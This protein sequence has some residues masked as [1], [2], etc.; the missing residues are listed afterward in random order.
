MALVKLAEAQVKLSIGK[1]VD[2]VQKLGD[3]E[4]KITNLIAAG[5]I[6]PSTDGL[7][8]PEGLVAG[9]QAAS[10]CIIPPPPPTDVVVQ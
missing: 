9:A 4:L 2:A 3:Y 5:K 10:A 8:T 7:T 1:L 6:F